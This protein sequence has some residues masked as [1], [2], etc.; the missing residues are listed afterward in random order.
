MDDVCWESFRKLFRKIHSD[1]VQTLFSPIVLPY[2]TF[3]GKKI[4]IA[5][6]NKYKDPMIF[7]MFTKNCEYKGTKGGE[8]GPS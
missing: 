8:N 4:M 6:K 1:K 3:D 2:F 7:F 5:S